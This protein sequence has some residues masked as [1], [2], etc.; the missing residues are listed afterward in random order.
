VSP[1]VFQRRQSALGRDT[2]AL[3]KS[4]TEAVACELTV[5][6]AF[7]F[8][9]G[10]HCARVGSPEHILKGIPHLV[11]IIVWIVNDETSTDFS[12]FFVIA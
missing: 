9:N 4:K 8:Q 12:H 2:V 1:S 3:E 7:R 5:R 10:M 6:D 11:I